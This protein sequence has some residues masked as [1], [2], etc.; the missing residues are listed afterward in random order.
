MQWASLLFYGLTWRRSSHCS[1]DRTSGRM[2]KVTSTYNLSFLITCIM[3]WL[4]FWNWS[5]F[6]FSSLLWNDLQRFP[7][8]LFV[9]ILT[10]YNHDGSASL[11]S[12]KTWK[13]ISSDTVIS[14]LWI[15]N[16]M[17]RRLLWSQ[18][19]LLEWLRNLQHYET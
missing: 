4:W 6:C 1:E 12:L 16:D 11:S 5:F 8:T 15:H 2:N 3:R 18:N 7:V 9:N 19:S 13:S 14:C 10:Q 17:L